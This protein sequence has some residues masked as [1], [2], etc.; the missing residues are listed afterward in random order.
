MSPAE[1][2][3]VHCGQAAQM[4][5]LNMQRALPPC[6]HSSNPLQVH[7]TTLPVMSLRPPVAPPRTSASPP[8]SPPMMSAKPPVSPPIS[9]PTLLP[10]PSALPSLPPPA[11]PA[12]G[13]K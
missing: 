11:P 6:H 5:L 13:C 12:Q 4:Q 9:A 10:P 3:V 1:R 2:Q 7:L 8:V